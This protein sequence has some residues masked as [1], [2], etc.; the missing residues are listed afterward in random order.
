[1][2]LRE[3]IPGLRTIHNGSNDVAKVSIGVPQGDELT[4]S[5]EV[6]AQLQSQSGA[7]KDGPAPARVVE[8][9]EA[10]KPAKV[11]SAAKSAK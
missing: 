11:K 3:P 9:V 2:A 8:A 1:M 5:D 4:V 10:V 6:A 7:F